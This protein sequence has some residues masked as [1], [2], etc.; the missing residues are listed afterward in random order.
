M[1]AV[2]CVVV[3]SLS[4]CS[5]SN[6]FKGNAG[7]ENYLADYKSAKQEVDDMFLGRTE[8]YVIDQLGEP[9]EREKNIPYYVYDKTCLHSQCPVM[10]DELLVF[11]NPKINSPGIGKIGQMRIYLK[12]ATVVNVGF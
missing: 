10:T 2:L 8:A 7:M 3:I 9:Q 11:N 5:T 12:E 1:L 4:S 6:L